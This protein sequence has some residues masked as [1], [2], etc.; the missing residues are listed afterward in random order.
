M[1]SITN[2]IAVIRRIISLRMPPLRQYAMRGYPIFDVPPH[3]ASNYVRFYLTT[4]LGELTSP[5]R[6][7]CLSLDGDAFRVVKVV[8]CKW[9][10]ALYVW[11]VDKIVSYRRNAD[12]QL[13]VREEISH[14][15]VVLHPLIE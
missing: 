14:H 10:P 15:Y 8:D 11:L 5:R 4:L 2:I 3:I 13:L 7:P 1:A 12:M 6:A 9:L